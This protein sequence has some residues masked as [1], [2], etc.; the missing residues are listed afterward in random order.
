MTLQTKDQAIYALVDKQRKYFSSGA[1]LQESFRRTQLQKLYDAVKSHQ[2]EICD[3]LFKDLGKSAHEAYLSEIGTTLSE[4]SHM[5]KHLH[6]Y[7]KRKYKPTPLAQFAATSYV[8]PAPLGNVLIIS[9]WNY[10]FFLNLSPLANAIAAGNTA[11]L[12]PSAYAPATGEVLQKLISAS[13]SEDYIAVITGGREENKALLTHKFDL[14]FFTGGKTVAK[15]VMRTASEHLSPMILELGGKS[16]CIVDATAKLKLAAKRIVF[17]KFLNCGQTCIAPDYILAEESIK[18]E[19]IQC[20]ITEIKAQFGEDVL[21]NP[22]YGKIINQKHFVRL[23]SLIQSDTLVYGGKCDPQTLRIEPT[24][25]NN[26]TWEDPV[27]ADE[28]FGPILSVIGVK[29]LDEAIS[30]VKAHPHPLAL[31]IFSESKVNQQKVLAHCQ[32]GGGC[33]NDT[34]IHIATTHMP[35]GGVGES[36]MGCYHGEKGFETFSHYRSIVDKK[37]FYDLPIRYQPYSKFKEKLIS[38]FLK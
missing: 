19:L 1:T 17:G 16:P 34:I 37:T 38:F 27:M 9:P 31:Y 23:S 26:V 18:E 25:L 20:L 5:K 36:G 21:N 33:I 29:D 12:K 4:I 24:I 28:V 3:A 7:M 2:A 13:F 11:I 8:S 22:N 32:F 6:S 35:F 30:M 10:P 15:E 14:L